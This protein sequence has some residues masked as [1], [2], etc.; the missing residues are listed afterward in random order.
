[1]NNQHEMNVSAEYDQYAFEL[2]VSPVSITEITL[3][4]T[5]NA[6]R[7]ATN[8]VAE[9]LKLQ[10]Q[11]TVI[12]PQYVQR[13]ALKS[14]TNI[15]TPA[16]EENEDTDASLRDWASHI[17]NQHFDYLINNQDE[18]LTNL[19]KQKY[20]ITA[21]QRKM[22][23]AISLDAMSRM[24]EGVEKKRFQKNLNSAIPFGS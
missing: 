1:M 14:E 16:A 15:N 18:I 6:M 23:K 17:L 22:L 8:L 2:P 9:L 5:I 7:E 12:Q 3:N 4:S 13:P 11:M 20:D 10:Q 19:T 24:S 21:N